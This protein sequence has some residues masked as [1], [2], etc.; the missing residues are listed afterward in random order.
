MYR[1]IADEELSLRAVAKRLTEYG[2]PTARGASYWR[3]TAVA[4]IVENPIYKGIFYYQRYESVQPRDQAYQRSLPADKKDGEETPSRVRLDTDTC[5]S[6]CRRESV[7]ASPA[8]AAGELGVF[9]P[10][11]QTAQLPAAESDSLF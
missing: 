9:A 1:W 10:E 2:L 5:A 6:Y 4:R 7:G 3:P 8:T 11:Q